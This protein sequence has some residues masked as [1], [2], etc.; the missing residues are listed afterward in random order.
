MKDIADLSFEQAFAE[1]EATVTQLERGD[2]PLE[3]SIALFERGQA[4]A[5]HCGLKLD[6]AELKVRQLLP[7]GSLEQ[8]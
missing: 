7:D 8:D 3:D 4:L 6:T 2:L 1:L 5:A